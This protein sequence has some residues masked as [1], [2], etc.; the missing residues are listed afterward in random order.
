MRCDSSKYERLQKRLEDKKK[1]L[2]EYRKRESEMLNSE[3]VQQYAVGS[4]SLTR[5]STDLR[6]VQDMIAK[7][8]QE[9][10]ELEGQLLGIKPR[11]AVGVVP[12]DN[13]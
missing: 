3:G 4:R 8:E 13:W 11:R 2:G 10:E 12:R 6:A 7:L 9:I 5:F 1:R